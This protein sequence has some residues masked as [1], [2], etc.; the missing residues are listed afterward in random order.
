MSI[1]RWLSELEEIEADGGIVLIDVMI[2]WDGKRREK[3][4]TVVITRSDTDYVYRRD[5]D[6][7]SQTLQDAIADYRSHHP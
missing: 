6:D 1:D 2:K 5:T 7:L 3:R 4:R